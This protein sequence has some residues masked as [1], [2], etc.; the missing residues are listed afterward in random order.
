MTTLIIFRSGSS[1]GR[2]GKEANQEGQEAKLQ[3]DSRAM[4]HVSHAGF[5]LYLSQIVLFVNGITA[6]RPPTQGV[7]DLLR[8]LGLIELHALPRTRAVPSAAKRHS[9]V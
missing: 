2:T 7:E 5:L 3:Q 6:D 4:V 9:G 1:V 8:C